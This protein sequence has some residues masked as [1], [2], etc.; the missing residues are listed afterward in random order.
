M[1]NGQR[2][3]IVNKDQ[4]YSDWSKKP[5]FSPALCESLPLSDKINRK[6]DKLNKTESLKVPGLR[7][8]KEDPV[9]FTLMMRAIQY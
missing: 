7:Q 2:G 6:K 9:E 5:T 8:N 1:E 4:T 3:R